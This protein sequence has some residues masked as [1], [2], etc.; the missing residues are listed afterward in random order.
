MFD[1]RSHRRRRTTSF[2]L[3]PRI[4]IELRLSIWRFALPRDRVITITKKEFRLVQGSN[5][6]MQRKECGS[7]QKVPSLLHVSR[8]ARCE[9]LR[10]YQLSLSTR[11]IK[12][13]YFAPKLD[14]I[15]LSR[16]HIDDPEALLFLSDCSIGSTITSLA[17]DR[18]LCHD[19]Q[20]FLKK[21]YPF[22]EN[23]TKKAMENLVSLNTVIYISFHDRT[24]PM[25]E[26]KIIYGSYGPES[27]L[28][29][30]ERGIIE[31]FFGTKLTCGH[32]V[33]T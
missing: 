17:I 13:F 26:T 19:L 28:S 10:H 6:E 24:I 2:H 27:F 1:I 7:F 14:T 16:Q 31:G 11:W 9:A 3:F 12:A 25:Q 23:A 20:S 33:K 22:A 21:E 8:E 30:D 15:Y 18:R 5:G 32:I 29:R 4:P